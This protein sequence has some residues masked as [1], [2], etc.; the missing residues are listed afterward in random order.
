MAPAIIT[1]DYYLVLKVDQSATTETI[2]K[3]YRQLALVLHPDRNKKHDATEA[4]QLV[5]PS[6]LPSERLLNLRHV[7]LPL[8]TIAPAIKS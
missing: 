4:F 8:L 6:F 5:R 3:S 7:F 1:E 2:I